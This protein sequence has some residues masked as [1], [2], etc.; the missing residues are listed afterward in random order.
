MEFLAWPVAVV[1]VVAVITHAFHAWLKQRERER[2]SSTDRAD[3]TK[4]LD[5]VDNKLREM[6]NTLANNGRR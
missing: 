3:L 1:V 5:D 2:L 4:R 6:K